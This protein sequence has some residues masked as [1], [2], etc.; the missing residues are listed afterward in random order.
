[1]KMPN[2]L[3]NKHWVFSEYKWYRKWYRGKWEKWWVDYPVASS[4]WH[5]EPLDTWFGRP[6]P[7][8]MGSPEEIENWG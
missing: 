6:S 7:L 8:C 3:R 1:M 5:N 2:W 4:V